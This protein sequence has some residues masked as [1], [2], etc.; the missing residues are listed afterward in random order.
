MSLENIINEIDN[1]MEEQK[2]KINEEYKKKI[3]EVTENCNKKIEEFKREYTIKSEY[4]KKDIIKQHED[5][6]KLQSK[7]IIDDK[8]K[9]LLKDALGKARSYILSLNKSVKYKEIISDMLKTCGKELGSNFII[10]CNGTEK[11]KLLESDNLKTENIVI[12]NSIRLGIKAASKDNK[13]FIDFTL[14]SIFDKISDDIAIY[15]YNNIE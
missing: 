5:N 1:S 4:D 10:Y 2:T 12:D 7:K 9:E 11:E 3:N 14:D 13:K 6:I 15:F 8:K